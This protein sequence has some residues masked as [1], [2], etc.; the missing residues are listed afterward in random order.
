MLLHNE[1]A[2]RKDNSFRPINRP[3]FWKPENFRC[4]IQRQLKFRAGWLFFTKFD[5]IQNVSGFLYCI[6]NPCIALYHYQSKLWS[7]K[8][9]KLKTFSSSP[10]LPFDCSSYYAQLKIASNLNTIFY[11][12]FYEWTPFNSKKLIRTMNSCCGNLLTLNLQI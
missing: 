10:W 7:A 3:S 12:F 6:R 2:R 4:A 5:F 9:L 1:F 11:N 8:T